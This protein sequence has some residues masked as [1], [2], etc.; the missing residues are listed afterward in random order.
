AAWQ[1]ARTSDG[2]PRLAMEAFSALFALVGAAMLARHAMNGGVLATSAPTLGEQAIYTLIM[3]GGGTILLALDLRSPSPVFRL[4]SMALGVL[5]V[6]FIVSAHLF[7]LNPL[8]TNESTG[9]LPLINLLLLAYLLPAGALLAL[10]WRAR[11]LRPDWYVR[12]L[13][14]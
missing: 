6:L 10:A 7:E 12:M 13:T 8:A 1:L 4:G 2:R 5:S 9:R 11:G 3:I 14:G